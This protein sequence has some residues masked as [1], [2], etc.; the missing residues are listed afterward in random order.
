MNGIVSH[1]PALCNLMKRAGQSLGTE[2]GF[3]SIYIGASDA[4]AFTQK[5]ISSC[6]LAA[7]NPGPP[8]YYHTRYDN[9]DNMD[10][11]C[12]HM[13]LSIVIQAAHIFASEGLG[14]S[15]SP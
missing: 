1:D 9:W 15:P 11:E 12:I 3:T 2:L 13:A 8:R 4:A 6:C 7:M 5:G 10:V 14:A